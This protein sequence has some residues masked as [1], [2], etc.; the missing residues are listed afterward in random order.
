MQTSTTVQTTKEDAKRNFLSLSSNPYPGRGFVVGT[1]DTGQHIVQ[2]YWIMGRGE[3]SRN[4]VFEHK[5]GFVF[6]E[7]ADSAKMKDPSLI[8]YNAMAETGVLF[9]V[10]NGK[11]TDTIL[12]M[13]SVPHYGFMDAMNQYEYEPD[14]PNFTPRIA[15]K[16][17]RYPGMQT[18]KT[19]FGMLRKSP[20]DDSVQRFSYLYEYIPQGFGFCLTT[21]TGDGNPLPP[22]R[23]E[24]V[25]MPLIGNIDELA[26]TYWNALNEENRVSLA[27]KLIRI[28]SNSPGAVKIINKYTK[29]KPAT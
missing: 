24:P 10:S 20:W 21:Y 22:F 4:R 5:N 23:D 18:Y 8:I 6:T 13:C 17:S 28:G 19:E 14:A 11:Q 2:V 26:H 15:A 3:N 16:V 25:L 27:V 29:V 12:E 1:D 7:A 9:V